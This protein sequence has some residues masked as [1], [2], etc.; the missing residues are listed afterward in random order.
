MTDFKQDG[1]HDWRMAKEAKK[2]RAIIHCVMRQRQTA[3]NRRRR[4][5]GTGRGDNNHTEDRGKTQGCKTGKARKQLQNKSGSQ[6]QEHKNKDHE[7]HGSSRIR[8]P[9]WERRRWLFGP[10]VNGSKRGSRETW[11]QGSGGKEVGRRKLKGQLQQ[12]M[13]GVWEECRW[14]QDTAR[15][16]EEDWDLV[17]GRG[18]INWIALTWLSL[19][20]T[21]PQLSHVL[22]RA[23]PP[24]GTKFQLWNGARAS[25]ELVESRGPESHVITSRRTSV[26]HHS[27]T[28][29]PS[30]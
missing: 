9:N 11:R 12:N 22:V 15:S 21:G 28:A 2:T 17:I 29:A 25:S 30:S 4:H 20:L 5:S 7:S 13:R 24:K 19:H 8:R 1:E 26:G 23:F 10:G 27:A 16:A 3:G 6:K 14:W 18:Q